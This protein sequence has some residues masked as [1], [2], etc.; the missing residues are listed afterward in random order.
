MNAANVDYRDYVTNWLENGW[1]VVGYNTQMLAMGN[2]TH[3]I[4]MQKE[5]ALRSV[6]V[7]FDKQRVIGTSVFKLAPGEPKE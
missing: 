5:G 1:S 6:A 2:V 3:F 4:L 7:L